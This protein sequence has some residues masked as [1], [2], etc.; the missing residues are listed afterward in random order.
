MTAILPL[1]TGPSEFQISIPES[2]NAKLLQEENAA[3]VSQCRLRGEL[4]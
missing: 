1:I 2:H 4:P 3:L